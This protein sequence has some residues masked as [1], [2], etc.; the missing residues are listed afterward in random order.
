MDYEQT[1]RPGSLLEVFPG[2]VWV[3]PDRPSFGWKGWEGS[4]GR[5]FYIKKLQLTQQPKLAVWIPV[6]KKDCAIEN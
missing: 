2:I 3:R 1:E 6:G 4:P 5:M